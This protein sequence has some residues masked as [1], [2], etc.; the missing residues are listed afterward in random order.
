MFWPTACAILLGL[1]LSNFMFMRKAKPRLRIESWGN[2]FKLG[3]LEK[4]I[5]RVE[6]IRFID[7]KAN[8]S[9]ALFMALGNAFDL[10]LQI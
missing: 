10:N 8:A 4:S 6:K 9:T 3:W 5:L 7:E 2:T 1:C